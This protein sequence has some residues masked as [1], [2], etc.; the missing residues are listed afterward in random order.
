MKPVEQ[1]AMNMTRMMSRLGVSVESAY[2]AGLGLPMARAA[3]RCLFCK[4]AETCSG[5]LE[6]PANDAPDHHGFCPNAELFDRLTD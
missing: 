3:H 4:N 5:W 6:R 2:G 1:R